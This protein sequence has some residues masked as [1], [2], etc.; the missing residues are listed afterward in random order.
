MTQ[1]R[2]S[3]SHVGQGY[4]R[5]GRDGQIRRRNQNGRGGDRR[6]ADPPNKPELYARAYN[7][8]LG[9]CLLK[10]DRKKEAL[11]A[12]LHVDQL[13]A[14]H[15]LAHAEA[16]KNLVALWSELGNPQR[17]AEAQQMLK[18]RYGNTRWGKG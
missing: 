1:Q 5:A 11:L 4:G 6:E 3:A 8:T 17:S 12:F 2:Q 9:N 13:Y 15:P 7:N 18:A 10:A 14:N 16:L